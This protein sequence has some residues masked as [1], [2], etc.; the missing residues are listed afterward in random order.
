M[1]LKN[2]SLHSD[3]TR[4]QHQT[5]YDYKMNIDPETRR[6]MHCHEGSGMLHDDRNRKQYDAINMTV[7]PD[8]NSSSR[9]M[10]LSALFCASWQR[11]IAVLFNYSLTLSLFPGVMSLMVWN[12]RNDGWFA[13]IQILVFNLTDTVG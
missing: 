1:G 6:I 12:Y 11:Q 13:V 2:Q 4:N 10:S 7:T 9:S 5:H 8:Q 3:F